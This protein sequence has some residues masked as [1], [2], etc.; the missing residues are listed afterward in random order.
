[1]HRPSSTPVDDDRSH[2]RL[3]LS[4]AAIKLI[5]HLLTNTRYGFHRDE[6]LYLEEARHLAWGFAE[7]PPLTPFLGRIALELG[8]SLFAVR[9]LPALAGVLSILLL[10]RLVRYLGGGRTAVLLACLTFLFSTAFLGSNTLY[11]PVSFNQL[12]WLMIAFFTIRLIARQQAADWYWL[13]LTAGFG[14]LNKYTVALYA[15]GITIG[16]LTSRQRRWFQTIHPYLALALS[17][18]VAFP[19]LR[20]QWQHDWP[21]FRHLQELSE[22][23]LV[24]VAP[25]DFLAAQLGMHGA[26]LLV[27]AAG[28]YW[29]FSRAGKSFRPVG[30][31][32]LFVITSLLLLSG[33]PYYA[34]GAYTALFAAGGIWW[35][36]WLSA[37]KPAWTAALPAVIFLLNLPAYPY[38]LPLFPIE[39][40]ARYGQ[41][42]R[43]HLGWEAPL[44]W[45]DG[46]VHQ[47]PQDYADMHGW[48]ELPAKVAAFYHRLPEPA[49]RRCL[50]WGGNYGHAG[51]LNYYRSAYDLPEAISLS[52]SY[53]LW[54]PDS[55]YFDRLLLVDDVRQDYSE[56]FAHSE[57]IDSIRHP[58]ARDPGYI[59]YRH[60]PRVDVAAAYRALMRER[61]AQ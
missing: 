52:S 38:S 33:K 43:D 20:W 56:W 11:Q 17:L 13:G 12:F 16:L 41:W 26:G 29:L 48:E 23:Q 40:M 9:L 57:L 39:N 55:L 10:G 46:Q 7:V 5:V 60:T 6:F 45:E 51:A 35:E 19:N 27:W 4:L 15:L 59:Y 47:L 32:F 18:A 14:W 37:K 2:W 22:T 36:Q 53:A 54:A 24:H 28:L 61:R 21:L 1:M 42:M 58:L 25:L 30:W 8:G 49:R 3:L 31:A 50:I 44:V 34:T